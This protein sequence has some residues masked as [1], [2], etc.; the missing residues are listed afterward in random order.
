MAS[1]MT[2]LASATQTGSA[3]GATIPLN[4][5]SML[6]AILTVTATS[7]TITAFKLWLEGSVDGGTTWAPMAP[8]VT[9]DA[10]A[11][12]CAWTAATPFVVNVSAAPALQSWVARYKQTPCNAVRV[13]WTLT[14]TTPSV[15]FAVLACGK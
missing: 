14:G 9:A 4:T 11:L 2:L 6:D 1:P 3:S 7:G 12:T 13:R 15:T 10:S 5:V 8:D